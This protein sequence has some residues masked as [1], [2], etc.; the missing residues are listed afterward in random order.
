[1]KEIDIQRQKGMKTVI[2]CYDFSC[3]FDLVNVKL[4]MDRMRDL[5]FGRELRDWI[6]VRSYL[7]DRRAYVEVND[8]VSEVVTLE[9]GTPQG[10]VV[11]PLLFLIL[12]SDMG[13]EFEGL[14][15]GYADDSTNI[16][17]GRTLEELHEKITLSIKKMMDYAGRTGMC[18]NIKKTEFLHFGRTQL[19][20]IQVGKVTLHEQR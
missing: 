5:G 19:Q 12:I 11:S 18:I 15:V 9:F 17:S 20:P 14:L 3:A 2:I 4:L 8:K 1:M 7:T 6:R 16:V 10:S 13:A